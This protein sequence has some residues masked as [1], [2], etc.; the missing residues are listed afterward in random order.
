MLWIVSE[1]LPLG[2]HIYAIGANEK[3]AALNGIPV[4][5]Y[6]IGVFVASGVIT[7][8]AGCVL[9]REAQNRPGEC[10]ARLSAAG[11]RRRLPRLDHDQAGPGQYLGHDVAAC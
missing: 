2:R 11:A 8:F 6:V 9:G 4:R 5:A 3:A 7:G 10:R 1:R